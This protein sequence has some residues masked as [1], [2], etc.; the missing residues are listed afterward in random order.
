MNDMNSNEMSMEVVDNSFTKIHRGEVVKGEVIYVNEN[1]V[2]VNINYKADGIITR[3]EVSNEPVDPRTLFKQ[4]DEI[5][6]CVL[7][8]DDGDGNVVLSY[9]KVM[10]AQIWEKLEEKFNNNEIVKVKVQSQIKGG[11]SVLVDGLNGFMPASQVSVNYIDDFS[12]FKGQTFDARIIDFDKGKRRLVVSKKVVDKEELEKNVEKLWETLEEGQT[13][14]GT[15]QRLTD[16]GAFVDLGGID[17]LIHISDLSWVRV[18]KP[19]EVVKVGDEVETLILAI[20]KE[21]NRISL[22]LKQTTEEPW[23]VFIRESKVGDIVEGKVVSLLDFGAFIKLKQGVDGLLHVSQISVEHVEKPSDVLQLGQT[24]R[25]KITEI[26]EEKK[27]ISLSIRALLVEDAKS[28]QDS[29]E[30]NQ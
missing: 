2:T 24:V 5:E 14:K 22:G 21:R 13:V 18:K 1:E 11:L 20:D 4:G 29:E 23:T 30:V 10:E 15:V 26:N 25:V 9:K 12:V 28:T 3:D 7:R 8:I 19:S 17:G 16:F 6:V 27:K